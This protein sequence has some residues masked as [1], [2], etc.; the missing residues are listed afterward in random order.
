MACKCGYHLSGL[1][2]STKQKM[3]QIISEQ[4]AYQKAHPYATQH[5]AVGVDQAQ[6]KRELGIE[7]EAFPLWAKIGVGL[8]IAGLA[9]YFFY[10]NS[11][12]RR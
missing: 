1:A 7:E 11:G 2:A 5:S 4:E 9:W 3:Q 10:E 6:A 12:R 8:S